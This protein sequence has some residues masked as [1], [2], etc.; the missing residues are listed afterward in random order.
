MKAQH[1][2]L[3]ATGALRYIFLSVPNVEVS[4]RIQKKKRKRNQ[5]LSFRV[6]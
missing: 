1:Q 5:F 6:L 3:T 2:A 4:H